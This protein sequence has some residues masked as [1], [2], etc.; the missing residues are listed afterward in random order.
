[1]FYI[2][3]FD[4]REEYSRMTLKGLELNKA[5]F[6]VNVYEVDEL[7]YLRH[8][9]KDASPSGKGKMK[10]DEVMTVDLF[11]DKTNDEDVVAL[12]DKNA[13][14]FLDSQESSKDDDD[15]ANSEEQS[16]PLIGTRLGVVSVGEERMRNLQG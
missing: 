10:A 5:D 1:M 14:L 13:T 9:D 12:G 3:H 16:I 2:L 8:P 15:E 6:A 4:E 11:S 7:K